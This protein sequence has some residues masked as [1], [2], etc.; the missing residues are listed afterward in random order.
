MVTDRFSLTG[1]FRL[2]ESFKQVLRVPSVVRPFILIPSI[3][4]E[5]DL[6]NTGSL[7]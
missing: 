1:P 5:V 3:A 6:G 4:W 2:P 7:R